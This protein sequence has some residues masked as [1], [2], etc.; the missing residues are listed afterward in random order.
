MQSSRHGRFGSSRLQE[1]LKVVLELARILQFTFPNHMRLP[2]EFLQ[3]RKSAFVAGHIS[4]YLLHPVFA[5]VGW[6]PRA[7]LAVVSMSETAV[8]KDHLMQSWECKVE[9]AGK[10][11]TAPA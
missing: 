2:A 7:A 11:F 9:L 3:V 6:N 5:V 8:N 10:V 4:G 1:A